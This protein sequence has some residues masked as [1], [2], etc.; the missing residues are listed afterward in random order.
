MNKIINSMAAAAAMAV[1]ANTA[2]AEASFPN[3]PITI[4]VPFSAGGPADHIARYVAR[5]Y[6]E[7]W[8]V[9]VVVENKLGAGGSIG[10]AEV[11]RSKPDG[12]TLVELVTGHTIMPGMLKSMPYKMPDAFAGVTVLNY[13]PK[14]VV[15]NAA[16]DV[17]S[18]KDLLAKVR[19]NP[20]KYANY[21]TSG[22]GSLAHLAMEQVNQLERVRL[23][24]IPYK[25]GAA[26]QTDLVAGRLSFGVLDLGSVLPFVES[27]KLRV[28][29]VTSGQRSPIFPDVPTI[30]ELVPGFEATEWFG[31]A[32]PAGTP[33]DIRVKLQEVARE[34]L[35]KSAA[36]DYY[37]KKLGWEL[38]ASTPQQM[39]ELLAVQTEKWAKLTKELGLKID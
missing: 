16:S 12:Y 11:A 30:E 9:E 38:P 13:A 3:R 1:C 22:V 7:K 20:G 29:A 26:T 18:F 10:A 17:T 19:Q 36:T 14:V 5:A 15:T 27:G 32:A 8:N 4:V 2:L 21:G 34:A 37:I 28:L 35:Q 25:G 31:L 33:L 23:V 6:T 24:H 39:D